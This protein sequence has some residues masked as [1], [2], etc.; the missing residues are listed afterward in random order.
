MKN[1][2]LLLVFVLSSTQLFAQNSFSANDLQAD[3]KLLWNALN[4]LHPGLYRHSDSSAM[5]QAYL[6]LQDDFSKEQSATETFLL[7]SEFTAKVKC[8]HT[9]LNP[10][11]QNNGI[12]KSALED[13]VLLPF[14]FSIVNQKLIVDKTI[15]PQIGKNSVVTHI[16][17]VEVSTILNSLSK[18]IKADGN[19][20]EKKIKDL[21]VQLTSKY[22]YFDYYFPMVYG[23]KDSVSVT[24]N[25]GESKTIQLVSKSERKE[26]LT[27]DQSKGTTSLY[28]DQWNYEVKENVAYLKLGTFVT[29][30]LSFDWEKYLDEFFEKIEAEG[31]QNLVIDIR[32]NEGGLTDAAK[33]LVKK[34]SKVKGETVFRKPHLAY[35]KVS[36]SLKP[37]VS[38]WSKLF[39]NNALWTKKLNENFRTAKFSAN[40]PKRIKKN[41]NAFAGNTYLLI[42]ESN[43]S[44]TFILA[45]ICKKNNYAVLVGKE[46]GGTKKGITAGQIFFLTLP[47]TK[48]EVDIPLI[49]RYPLTD[50]PDEGIQPDIWVEKT[51]EGVVSNRDEVLEKTMELINSGK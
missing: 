51:I 24:L 42:D 34:L 22:E 26:G 38:T 49:G 45:E 7:L 18:Y 47:H 20:A 9:Y 28:D 31:I 41:K 17:D 25:T 8:G 39:Y 37:H 43:S 10:F 5:K 4:E 23:I 1:K 21:E 50:L 40:K 12:I 36:D 16:N 3:A 29:W 19:R 2:I 46:T 11:N 30:R 13:K 6:S 35:K 32:G 48:I 14:S 33:Y 15:H 44:A 27:G